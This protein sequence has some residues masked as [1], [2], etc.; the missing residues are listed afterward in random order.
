MI[1]R[2]LELRAEYPWLQP[3][4]GAGGV[5]D[6]GDLHSAHIDLSGAGARTILN[7]N[8]YFQELR[9][10]MSEDNGDITVTFPTAFN[11]SGNTIVTFD[12]VDDIRC[13]MSEPDDRSATGFRWRQISFNGSTAS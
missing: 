2:I 3:D 4:P 12:D 10:R 11:A 9:L 7:P 13:F 1:H 6:I 5:I 8:S